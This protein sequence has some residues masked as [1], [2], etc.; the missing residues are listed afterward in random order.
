MT[1]HENVQQLLRKIQGPA[2]AG[3]DADFVCT[4]TRWPGDPALRCLD[5]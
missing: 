1:T 2:V 5:Y 4:L 3:R